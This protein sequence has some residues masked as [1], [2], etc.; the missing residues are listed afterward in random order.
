MCIRDRIVSSFLDFMGVRFRQMQKGRALTDAESWRLIRMAAIGVRC[1]SGVS[2]NNYSKDIVSPPER[3]AEGRMATVLGQ[4]LLGME[5]IGVNERERWRVLGKIVL[6][7]MPELRR[8]IMKMA[9]ENGGTTYAEIVERTGCSK[10]VVE[11]AVED[12]AIHRAVERVKEEKENGGVRIRVVVE[13]RVKAEIKE[14]IG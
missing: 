4:L 2:R 7:S 6:D 11:R 8:R 14:V 3:E 9:I 10:S 13:E 5:W 1:R 12:L